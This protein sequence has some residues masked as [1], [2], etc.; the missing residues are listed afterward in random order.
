MKKTSS[1]KI[2]KTNNKKPDQK[3]AITSTHKTKKQNINKINLN[4]LLI[5]YD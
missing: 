3:I 2:Y 1:K 4:D 5:D